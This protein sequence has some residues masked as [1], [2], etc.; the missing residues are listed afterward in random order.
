[1]IPLKLYIR[2]DYDLQIIRSYTRLR[3][4]L[5]ETVIVTNE[6]YT[7]A[8]SMKEAFWLWMIRAGGIPAVPGEIIRRYGPFKPIPRRLPA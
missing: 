7:G 6:D 1:M 5:G 8:T 4:A 2:S 3:P